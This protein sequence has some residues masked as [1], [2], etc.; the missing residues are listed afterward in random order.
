M[1]KFQLKPPPPNITLI[2][3]SDIPSIRTSLG[4]S[5][6]GE[7]AI[8]ISAGLPIWGSAFIFGWFLQE[9]IIYVLIITHFV[10]AL[11]FHASLVSFGKL[12]IH[13]H[14]NRI[15]IQRSLGQLRQIHEIPLSEIHEITLKQIAGENYSYRFIKIKQKNKWWATYLWGKKSEEGQQ[16][17]YQALID[18]WK[19]Y[20]TQG[21]VDD[22]SDHLIS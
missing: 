2:E 7:V 8:I 1:Q 21:S 18:K 11:I 9:G 22:L 19:Q 12:M 10:G 16:Y 4:I 15:E 14:D 6:L 17:I 3:Q 13:F 5:M 20:K